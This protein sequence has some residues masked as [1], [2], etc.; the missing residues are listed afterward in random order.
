MTYSDQVPPRPTAMER[1]LAPWRMRYV[2]GGAAESGCIFCNR[3]AA[4]DDVSSLILH[5]EPEAMVIMNLYPYNTGHVMIVPREHVA[6]PEAM[7]NAA[8][9]AMS[10]LLPPVLRALRMGLGCH[11]FN[12]GMNIGAVAGAGVA[13]HLHQHLVP[14]WTGDANFMPIIGATMVLPELIP[15]TYAKLRAELQRECVALNESAATL[16]VIDPRNETVLLEG[17]GTLPSVAPAP[18]RPV[19]E[20]LAL[21]LESR[22]LRA[23]LAGWAGIS[24]SGTNDPIALTFVA[25]VGNDASG[26]WVPL[27]SLPT[28]GTST[29]EAVA[30]ARSQCGFA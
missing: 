25:Q 14:R 17:D 24:R 16:V 4:G 18:G 1:I 3:F 8:L 30:R 22:G 2:G 29:S 28:A 26:S 23:E 21:H 9:A 12:I 19:L 15:V 7:S 11:G 20:A 27:N 13:E 10:S 5:R 6:S